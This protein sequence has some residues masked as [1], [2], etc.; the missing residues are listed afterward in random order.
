M[1]FALRIYCLVVGVAF[2]V[3]GTSLFFE[4]RAYVSN[5]DVSDGWVRVTADLVNAEKHYV[6]VKGRHEDRL[7]EYL[8]DYSATVDGRV[9]NFQYTAPRPRHVTE[10]RVFYVKLSQYHDGYEEM[11][12]ERNS[13][14]QALA[15]LFFRNA[16]NGN[17]VR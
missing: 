11:V 13:S 16:C 17:L 7:I 14:D 6:H 12:P 10:S 15:Y 8:G 9:L 4:Y 1:R 5:P 3:A 2:I